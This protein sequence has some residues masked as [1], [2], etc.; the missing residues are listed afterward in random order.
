MDTVATTVVT[1]PVVVWPAARDGFAVPSFLIPYPSQ[2]VVLS[3]FVAAPVPAPAVEDVTVAK[4][5]WSLEGIFASF[6]VP[7]MT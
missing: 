2:S 3:W 7:P 6:L 1:D 5:T 4:A